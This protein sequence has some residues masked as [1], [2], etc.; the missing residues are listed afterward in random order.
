MSKLR[1]N[2]NGAYKTHKANI[3]TKNSDVMGHNRVLD[4]HSD[5]VS[6]DSPIKNDISSTRSIG[7]KIKSVRNLPPYSLNER[8][9]S[10]RGLV[11]KSGK[12]KGNLSTAI[13]NK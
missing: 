10:L 5:T 3:N 13:Y 6:V 8:E 9:K 1:K 2:L 4:L 12:S 11:I 7:D